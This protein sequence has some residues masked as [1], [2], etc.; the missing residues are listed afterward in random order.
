[1]VCSIWQA[2]FGN[3]QTTGTIFILAV[4]VVLLRILKYI[5]CCVAARGATTLAM[6]MSA[7]PPAVGSIRGVLIRSTTS[8]FVVPAH[9]KSKDEL[10]RMKDE[11]NWQSLI[12][13]QLLNLVDKQERMIC[14]SLC[15]YVFHQ[16]KTR[17]ARSVFNLLG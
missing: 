12:V 6:P 9:D 15:F 7:L 4:I 11:N 16:L 13:C 1:M 2:M 10:R 3:G 8:A 5:K 17:S 14:D